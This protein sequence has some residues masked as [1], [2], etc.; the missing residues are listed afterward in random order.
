[1]KYHITTGTIVPFVQKYYKLV[2]IAL[3]G[4]FVSSLFA[5]T[6]SAGASTLV[7]GCSF[8]DSVSGVW[9]LEGNCTVT[10]QIDIPSDTTLD[11]NNYTM[12]AG[13]TKT[14]NSNNA[15][16]GVIGEDNVT[17][18]NLVIEGSGGTDLHAINTYLS[19]NVNIID[20]TINNANRSGVVVNGT[21]VTVTNITTSGS[22]W[23]AINVA[24]GSGVSAPSV[25]TVNGVSSH[26]ATELNIYLDDLSQDVTVNDTNSQYDYYFHPFTSTDGLYQLKYPRKAEITAPGVNEYVSGSVDFNAYLDDDDTD[27]IQWAI[28]QGTCAAGT[29]TVFGNVDGHS[30]VATIDQSDVSMQTFE[31]TA[32]MSVLSDGMY[33]FIYNP[34]E[35]SGESN[36]RLTREFYLDNTAPDVPADLWRV[37]SANT[38]QTLQCGDVT[39]R[40]TLYPTWEAYTGLDFSHYEYNS[41]NNGTP[42]IVQRSLLT[43]QFVHSWIP[44]TDG[45]FG[46]QVRTVDLA[47]NV[48]GWSTICEIIYDSV[49]PI[50]TIN[51]PLDSD[52]VGGSAVE[53]Y[54]TV[55][56]DNLSHYNASI[57]P[58]TTDLSDGGTHSADRL[59][60]S[61]VVVTSEF[62]NQIVLTFDSTLLADGDYQIR[63]AARDLAGNRDTTDPYNGGTSSVHV[64]AVSVLNNPEGDGGNTDVLGVSTTK[65]NDDQN[66]GSVL[67]ATTSTGEVLAQTDTL[68]DT[69]TETFIYTVFGVL[70]ITTTATL[71]AVSVKK[72]RK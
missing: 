14:D 54:G 53:V 70:L 31:F 10:A 22:G 57:Y 65:T 58:S 9:S 47:G 11:G 67:G 68:T 5:M 18:Q 24:Q 63:L 7:N 51:L 40:Q 71:A 43:N 20:V 41:F 21:D 12:Y 49:P 8:D 46:F 30:D 3:A 38:S 44:P 59:V 61:G 1:M 6:L 13:F 27:S 72:T 56:D 62:N 39:T 25:L 26:S 37:R 35:D 60:D 23:H 28:R 19:V 36:I 2:V 55:T 69:G 33:C 29:N 42:G 52:V 50:V 48:S 16:L 66:G 17:I 45:T 32:D 4:M 15:V 34:V 64:I